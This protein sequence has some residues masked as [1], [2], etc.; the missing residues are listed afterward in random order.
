M[1]EQANRRLQQVQAILSS[2]EQQLLLLPDDTPVI[3]RPIH[4]EKEATNA[5]D[6]HV[7]SRVIL[8]CQPTSRTAG[9][10]LSAL[11][12]KFEKEGNAVPKYTILEVSTKIDDLQNADLWGAIYG[13]WALF[14]TQEYIPVKFSPTFPTHAVSYLIESGLA[15]RAVDPAVVEEVFVDRGTFW[16]GAG[17]GPAWNNMRGW[18]RYARE[19]AIFPHTQTFTRTAAV[20]AQHPLRPPK[21]PLGSI[22]YKRWCRPVGKMLSFHVLDIHDEGDM[23]AFHRWHNEP[24]VNKGWGEAGSMEKHKAYIA[25][26]IADPGVL[27]LIMSWD[28]ERMGYTEIVWIKENHVA[29]YVPNGAHDY[30]RGMHVLCGEDKFRGQVYSQAWFR[31]IGHYCFLSDPRTVRLVGE[32]KRSN[33]AILK[34]S[35]DAG[36]H[37][38][39][40]FYFPY[41][42]SAMTMN[43][44]ER[45]FKEDMLQ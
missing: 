45:L 15:R 2:G 29:P 17:T 36:M 30:D 1:A 14:S 12:T 19:Y 3:I 33:P 39:T 24:R 35:V 4:K 5:F 38:E 43:L 44:R 20:I 10:V 37:F 6:I 8:S 21:P 25:E 16:Q 40:F 22:V 31:S 42:Y 27:P 41:K 7:G 11:G 9:L 13:L 26:L 34:T 23:E 28:G 32:P 18:L